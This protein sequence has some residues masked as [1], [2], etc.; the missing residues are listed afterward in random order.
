MTMKCAA[1][2]LQEKL[3]ERARIPSLGLSLE[4]RRHLNGCESCQTT[5]E[6]TR[7]L[8]RTWQSLAPSAEETAA[9]R[10]RISNLREPERGR[11]R[12]SVT[13]V[14][15]ILV[16]AAAGS[17][18]AG[19]APSRRVWAHLASAA[20]ATRDAFV[21][22]IGKYRHA[23]AP[24]AVVSPLVARP[25]AIESAAAALPVAPPDAL[26]IERNGPAA[27][28]KGPSG[29]SLDA[30]EHRPRSSPR[31]ARYRRAGPARSAPASS[32]TTGPNRAEP[33]PHP[34]VEAASAMR[35]GDYPRAER[36]LEA[37]IG[38]ADAVTRDAARLAR[39]QI[40][41]AQDR[42]AEAVNELDALS[43]TGATPYVRS[44]AGELRQD[45]RGFSASK[46]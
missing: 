35:A 10:K 25:V 20:V 28:A 44:R 4:H 1:P 32:V 42:A 12:T 6:R 40:W 30:N 27:L 18:A 8:A 38:D 3:L 23:E 41:L 16:L 13:L 19:A 39:A 5:V 7:R 26:P 43:K 21:T 33:P 46:K 29:T 24:S 2:A 36:A 17:A 15:A 14:F 11:R 37:L 31:R 34:W 9:V 45:M 22:S